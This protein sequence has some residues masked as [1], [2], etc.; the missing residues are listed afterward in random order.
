MEYQHLAVLC[1]QDLKEAEPLTA[2]EPN[3][4]RLR[5]DNPEDMIKPGTSRG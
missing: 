5:L 1:M 2:V 3:R 4:A